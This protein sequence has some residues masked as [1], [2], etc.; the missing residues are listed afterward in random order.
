MFSFL[1]PPA[2]KSL[3]PKEEVDAAYKRYRWQ[4][5]LGIFIGYAGYYLVRK[6]FTLAMPDL[7]EQGF[8]KAELGLALS[9]V[10]I[11]YGISKLVMGMVSDKSNARVFMPLGLILSGLTMIFMGLTHWATLSVWTMFI[12]LALNG[13]FQGMGWPPSGRIMVYWF[14]QKE[15]ASKMSWWNISHNVGG[16][17]AGK[18]AILGTILFGTWH[19]KLFFPGFVVLFIALIAFLL[20]RDTP[21]SCGL[22]D[23]ET[24]HNSK[25]NTINT[26]STTNLSS[27]EIFNKYILRNKV[28]WLISIANV[29]VYLVRNGVVDWAPTYLKEAKDYDLND[30]GWA[31]FLYEFAGIP[32]TLLCGYLSDKL[33]KGNRSLANIVFMLLV[34][35]AVLV[36]WFNPKGNFMIDQIALIS[37]GFFIYGPVMLIGVFA[38]D[39]VPREAAGTAA[40][41][42][43]FFGYLGGAAFANIG[44]GYVVDRWH[45]NGGFIVI[46]SACILAILISISTYKSESK[47][48]KL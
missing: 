10:S 41:F 21:A 45:W 24:Y 16:A 28:L 9:G 3:L 46:V 27:W 34:T 48:K 26:P 32:G 31:T 30:Q 4:V 47:L 17:L 19:S 25:N 36:Y 37:I 5:F 12:I 7:I 22:P 11:A 14:S 2:A 40:G 1:K 8:T 29:F 44:F 38:L 43:G 42:T 39:L 33:F 23:I 15:R 20:I 35:V 18:V 13:W 6:N